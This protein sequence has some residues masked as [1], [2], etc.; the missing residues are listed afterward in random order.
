[1]KEKL[2]DIQNLHVAVEDKKILN[3]VNLSMNKGEVHVVLGPNGA[4][5]STLANVIM[6]S[7]HL[8]VS[9]GSISYMGE[10]L[11]SLSADQRAKKG[12]FLSFQ[13]P[14]E[15]EG[16]NFESFL[17][18]AKS[19]IKGEK[20]G[21]LKFKREL[22][23]KMQQLEIPE[24]YAQR[25]LNVGFS[26]GEKKKSE[27]LQMAVLEPTLSIL[28]ETDSGLDIDAVKVVSK[29]IEELLDSERSILIITHHDK[30]MEHIRPDIV[31]VLL[32]GK[33]VKTSDATLF[34]KVTKEG[35]HWLEQEVS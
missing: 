8:E 28:D 26:G 25:Y 3:G 29:G 32:D 27:I 35:F 13:H 22:K 6:G 34:D 2:I 15:I 7:P 16:I 23:E 10:D 31:H 11:L 1:M 14:Y 33:I 30:I 20:I 19:S 4:G 5:K 9:Q 24:E 12:I 17:R 21:I 18:T